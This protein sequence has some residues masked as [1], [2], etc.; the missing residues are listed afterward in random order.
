MKESKKNRALTPEQLARK[1]ELYR[2]YREA[3]AEKIKAYQEEYRINNK[4]ILS[5]RKKEYYLKVR[6]SR[7]EYNKQYYLKNKE[8]SSEASRQYRKKNPQK[9]A[10]YGKNYRD[11]NK[12]AIDKKKREYLEANPERKAAA[13]RSRRA[14]KRNAEG[15]HVVADVIAIFEKQRGLCA[16]CG[17]RL[18]RSGPSK[19]HV[20]HIVPLA[21]G[22]SNWPSNLQ[23]LCKTCNLSKGAKDPIEWA[24]QN[25]MLI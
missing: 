18:L 24:N 5:E 22:G 25:G 1:A 3:N 19:Y 14:R 11:K 2:E 10:E 13:G 23:C 4:A 21:L 6:D 12:D 17:E 7:I 9:I 15:H 8:A 20:D 16:Y